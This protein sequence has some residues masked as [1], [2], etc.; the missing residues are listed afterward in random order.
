[1]SKT[2]YVNTSQIHPTNG[3]EFQESYAD[4]SEAN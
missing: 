1:M 2:M 3:N 4:V